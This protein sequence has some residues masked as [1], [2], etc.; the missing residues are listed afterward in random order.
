MK[1]FLSILIS[2]FV[3][4]TSTSQLNAEM[5]SNTKDDITIS[6]EATLGSNG[7][8]HIYCS[9]ANRSPYTLAAAITPTACP[10]FQFKLQD[11]DG[12]HIL[13]DVEWAQIHQQD[14]LHDRELSHRSMQVFA[15]YTLTKQEFQ[16]DLEDAYGERAAQGKN[17]DVKW[18]C[19]YGN[20]KALI[21]VPARKGPDGKVIPAHDEVNHFPGLWTVSVTIPLPKKGGDNPDVKSIDKPATN[22]APD[23][24]PQMPFGRPSPLGLPL[25]SEKNSE[26][27]AKS[28]PIT[29]PPESSQENRTRANV[30][31]ESQSSTSWW[32][33]LLAIPVLVLAWLGFRGRKKS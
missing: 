33:C 7:K 29:A 17:L 5:F 20:S 26:D 3:L 4:L 14:E 32:W 15:V 18:R 6:A 16:F 2:V 22:V 8:I 13:Q 30:I 27:G 28:P 19:I 21:E 31:S 9:L 1:I 23:K 10:C 12:N 11:S 24:N 25:L